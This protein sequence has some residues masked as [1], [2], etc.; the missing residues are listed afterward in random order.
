MHYSPHM[1]AFCEMHGLSPDH[2]NMNLP[3]SREEP[4]DW[5]DVRWRLEQV[6]HDLEGQRILQAFIIAENAA[7]EYLE[8]HPSPPRPIPDWLDDE[9]LGDEKR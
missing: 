8:Q 9:D 1:A 3:C 7:Y 5:S 4:E 2:A 6:A